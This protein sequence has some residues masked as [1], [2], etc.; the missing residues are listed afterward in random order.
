MRRLASDNDD[1]AI[2]TALDCLEQVARGLLAADDDDLIVDLVER[3][4]N[5]I[6][7]VGIDDV[8]LCA[9]PVRPE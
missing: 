2:E 9:G 8:A 6:D 4:E 1:A 5:D 3:V 7:V